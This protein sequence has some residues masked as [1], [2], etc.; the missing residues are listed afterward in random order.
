MQLFSFLKKE[1]IKNVL[2][3]ITGSAISQVII[4]TAILLLTRL[5]STELFGIYILFS[6]A[7]VIL[8]PVATLQY[9]FA[10]VLPK[11]NE[12][13]INLLAFSILT[14]ICYCLLL[15]M[16]IFFF[17]EPISNFFNIKELSNFIYLLPLNIFFFGC[18]SI[19]DFWNNRTNQFKNISKGL[20]LK[21]TVMSTS[22]I[23]TGFSAFNSLGL[24]P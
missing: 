20:L 8:K 22:Q 5:F 6:S 9:E 24:I 21:S 13:A 18:V 3:L 2:T 15:L 4:Y 23:A 16:I 1:F 7:T 10:I 19:F 17:K 12:D 14:L 11:K